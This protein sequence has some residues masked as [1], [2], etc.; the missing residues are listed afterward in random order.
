MT[1]DGDSAL[2]S[3]IALDLS[4]RQRA[5]RP[6]SEK[7]AVEATLRLSQGEQVE[8]SALVKKMLEKEVVP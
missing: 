3:D 8:S 4:R 6:Q 2:S 1:S 7:P 5:R